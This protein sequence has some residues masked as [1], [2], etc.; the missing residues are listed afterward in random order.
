MPDRTDFGPLLVPKRQAFAA[1]GVGNTKGHELINAGFLLARKLGTR[2][3][4][5]AESLRSFAAGLPAL[6]RKTP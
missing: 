6:P 4:I 5:E 1:L 3:V 2:T